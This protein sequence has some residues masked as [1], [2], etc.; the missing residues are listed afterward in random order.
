MHG[1]H[2]P[3]ICLTTQL[4]EQLNTKLRAATEHL[5]RRNTLH[6]NIM[7][8][9]VQIMQTFRLSLSS[10]QMSMQNRINKMR[11]ICDVVAETTHRAR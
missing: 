11:S 7:L 9:K 1:T 5:T 8:Q 3:Q 4:G 6:M 10:Q 2:I